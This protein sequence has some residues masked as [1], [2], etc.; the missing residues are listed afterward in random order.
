M[1]KRDDSLRS[2]GMTVLAVDKPLRADI[3]AMAAKKGLTMVDYL[4]LQVE[5]DKRANPQ[6]I[7]SPGMSPAVNSKWTPAVG[8]QNLQEMTAFN[9]GYISGIVYDVFC[10]KEIDKT[11]SMPIELLGKAVQTGLRA[12]LES[13]ESIQ[14]GLQLR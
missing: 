13:I 2:L 7:L 6:A 12:A 11:A 8:F 14:G 10:V 5:K 3:K 4:R 9:A 1:Q